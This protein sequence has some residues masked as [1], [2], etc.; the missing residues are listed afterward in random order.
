MSTGNMPNPPDHLT[1]QAFDKDVKGQNT[2]TTLPQSAE[3]APS[4]QKEAAQPGAATAQAEGNTAPPGSTTAPASPSQAGATTPVSAAASAEA[5]AEAEV[6]AAPPLPLNEDMARIIE[7]QLGTIAQQLLY[8]SQLMFGVG[9]LG[10]DPVTARDAAFHVAQS[11]REQ[12]LAPGVHALVNLG[13]SQIPQVN[14]RTFPFNYNAQVAGLLE[15]IIAT[16]IKKAYSDDK[17]RQKQALGLL[18]TIF[19]AANDRLQQELKMIPMMAQAPAMGRDYLQLTE[20]QADSLSQ[21]AAN[22]QG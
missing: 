15:G 9:G 21:Q 5:P 4:Q 1:S 8:H 13:D 11:L 14:D 19:L 18:N 17:A 3:A 20:G 7:D 12:S 2:P 16:S 6:E 22:A 10:T